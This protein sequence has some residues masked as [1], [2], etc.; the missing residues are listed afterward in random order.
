MKD[1][2]NI[3][4]NVLQMC[5]VREPVTKEDSSD[6]STADGKVKL[7]PTRNHNRTFPLQP[8]KKLELRKFKTTPSGSPADVPE[9]SPLSS[10]EPGH[11]PPFRHPR[12]ANT[13][14]LEEN[15][16]YVPLGGPDYLKVLAKYNLFST[17]EQQGRVV[18]R[19]VNTGNVKDRQ[20]QIIKVDNY[21]AQGNQEF[22]A[23]IFIGNPPQGISKSINRN[24]LLINSRATS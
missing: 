21:S 18:C 19:F 12:R 10:S 20:P 22:L 9:A 11:S 3:I 16:A 17:D 1:G 15:R 23:H 4:Q 2:I 5:Q 6:I 14:E 7:E 13:L 8:E 24:F